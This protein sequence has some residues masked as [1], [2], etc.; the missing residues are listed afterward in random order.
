MLGCAHLENL[1]IG[2]MPQLT[3]D[4]FGPANSA[5]AHLWL[6]LA[7]FLLAVHIWDKYGIERCFVKALNS[8][9]NL[10]WLCSNTTPRLARTIIIGRYSKIPIAVDRSLGP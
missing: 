9:V 3:H 10:S 6:W 8:A 4:A 1:R 7:F 5:P 2:Q